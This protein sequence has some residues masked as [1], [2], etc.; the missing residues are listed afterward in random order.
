MAI[1]TYGG[2]IKMGKNLSSIDKSN[3]YKE[4]P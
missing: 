2:D 4:F 3:K 1:S